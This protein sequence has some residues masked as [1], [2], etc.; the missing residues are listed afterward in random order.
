MSKQD[1][2][3]AFPVSDQGVHG[4]YGMS[5]RAYF[6]GQ[7]LMGLLA[8]IPAGAGSGAVVDWAASPDSV[9]DLAIKHADTLIARLADDGAKKDNTND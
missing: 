2:G 1:G 6:A 9:A 8:G 7:A 3:P 4:V 5:L